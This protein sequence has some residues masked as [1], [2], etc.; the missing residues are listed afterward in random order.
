MHLLV[1][2]F[3]CLSGQIVCFR[4]LICLFGFPNWFSA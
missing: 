2:K 4:F 1:S 3:S